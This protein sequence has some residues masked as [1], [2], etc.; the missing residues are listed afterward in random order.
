MNT[1]DE[2]LECDQQTAIPIT[3]EVEGPCNHQHEGEGGSFYFCGGRL[4]RK[5]SASRC[6]HEGGNAAC[7]NACPNLL[8]GQ[9]FGPD[10]AVRRKL[11]SSEGGGA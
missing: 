6:Y 10:G 2:T 7:T 3:G 9:E 8:P 1:Y 11:S 5:R 4:T